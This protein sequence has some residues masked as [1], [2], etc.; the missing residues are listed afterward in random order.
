M[1]KLEI[2]IIG[3]GCAGFSLARFSKS[4]KDYNFKLYLGDKK[5]KSQNHFWS[6]WKNNYVQDAYNNADHIWN[7]WAI[8]T[9]NSNQTLSSKIYPYCALKSKSWIDYCQKKAIAGN[10]E[11]IEEKVFE[12]NNNF[13]TINNVKISG[14]YIFDSRPPMI[15]KNSL[16]QH[17]IGCVVHSKK[18]IFKTSTAILMDFRCDQSKGIHFIYLLPL[19]KRKALVESTLF[20]KRIE[21]KEFYI[22]SIKLYLKNI[23][24][25]NEFTMSDFENGII[26]MCNLNI[27]SKNSVSIGSRGGAI[28]PSSG[29]VFTFIQKQTLKI[30]HKIYNQNQ[31]KLDVHNRFELFMDQV[32]LKVM[33]L[34]PNRVPNLFE[35]FSNAISGDEMAKFMSGEGNILI[36]LKVIKS[37]PKAPFLFAFYKIIFR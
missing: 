5:E 2:N 19:S 37:M 31:F 11:I 6:F 14:E 22:N 4:L 13:Y 26:P 23:Y 28:R 27:K 35:R 25:L 8:I 12:K 7:K 3:G 17:F 24:N 16:L 18:N 20:S 10:V 21:K 33:E 30:K 15:P 34:Y 36:W 9:N 1:S 29:Y 32:F